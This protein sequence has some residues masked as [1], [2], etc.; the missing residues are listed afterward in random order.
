MLPC[1]PFGTPVH[2]LEFIHVAGTSLRLRRLRRSSLSQL[3]GLSRTW[4]EKARSRDFPS[5]DHPFG[6][7]ILETRPRVLCLDLLHIIGGSEPRTSPAQL[8]AKAAVTFFTAAF[9]QTP[10]QLEVSEC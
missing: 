4:S 8:K 6:N 10:S 2:S 7:N 5:F 1:K 3:R 9:L